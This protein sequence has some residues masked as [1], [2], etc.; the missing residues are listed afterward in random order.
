MVSENR[1]NKKIILIGGGGHSKVILNII[2]RDYPDI[3]I[4]GYISKEKTDINVP[5]LGTEKEILNFDP[6]QYYLVFAI[7]QLDEGYQRKKLVEFFLNK[8][9]N[10]L[11][12]ISK[13]SIVAESVK[14]GKGSVVFDGVIINVDSLIGDFCIINTGCIVEHDCKIG[15]FVHLA[16]RATLSGGV[17]IGDHCFLGAGA[18]VKHY[19]EIADGVIVGA[20]GV[21]VESILYPG[22]YVGVPARRIK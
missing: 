19:T 13:N 21:V 10:F 12:L 1:E 2:T 11:T 16:P 20:G 15:N 3:Q 6:K 4:I 22:V 17:K 18:V 5:Y 7:G 14:I 9:F 8:G